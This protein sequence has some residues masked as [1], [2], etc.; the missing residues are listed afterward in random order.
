M[1]FLDKT[2]TESG[3]AEHGFINMAPGDYQVSGQ[4]PTFSF[5][6]ALGRQAQ[7]F[8]GVLPGSVRSLEGPVSRSLGS[9]ECSVSYFVP[10]GAPTPNTFKVQFTI[11]ASDR[12]AGTC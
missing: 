3:N 10:F 1:T 11:I 8:G 6:V 5:T 7:G 9:P 4:C 2:Y 12:A